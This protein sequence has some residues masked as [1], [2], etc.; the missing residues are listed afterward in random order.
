MKSFQ[1]RAISLFLRSNISQHL[2]TIRHQLNQGQQNFQ[3]KIQNSVFKNIFCET[4]LNGYKIPEQTSTGVHCLRFFFAC[5]IWLRKSKWQI[6]EIIQ[7]FLGGLEILN[8]TF[9][10]QKKCPVISYF[11]C[12]RS[13]RVKHGK[14]TRPC[15]SPRIHLLDKILQCKTRGSFP[16]GQEWAD[17]IAESGRP[18]VRPVPLS[19]FIVMHDAALRSDCSA[20]LPSSFP[21]PLILGE[22][23]CLILLRMRGRKWMGKG[24]PRG[25][26]LIQRGSAWVRVPNQRQILDTKIFKTCAGPLVTQIQVTKISFN[27]GGGG[28]RELVSCSLDLPEFSSVASR[29]GS[30]ARFLRLTESPSLVSWWDMAGETCI[31]FLTTKVRD[32][33]RNF[34]F[35]AKLC[36][37]AGGGVGDVNDRLHCCLRAS[38]AE[39]M[40][41]FVASRSPPG[42]TT[43]AALL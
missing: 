1:N 37:V 42:P 4:L 31:I 32:K 29:R 39:S 35:P 36:V 38:H 6:H 7:N 26:G 12:S 11:W 5:A 3:H 10:Q 19:R 16:V 34:F 41:T 14:Q 15:S 33:K 27:V 21:A 40:I 30:R 23:F 25:W 24:E 8:K 22:T 9:K 28:L 17:V 20:L 18:C 2:D 13:S 43:R